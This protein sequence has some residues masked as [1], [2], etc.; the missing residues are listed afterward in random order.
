MK[1]VWVVQSRPQAQWLCDTLGML[2]EAGSSHITLDLQVY[3]T[4]DKVRVEVGPNRRRGQGGI[5]NGGE[6]RSRGGGGRG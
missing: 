3:V 2:Q 6:G 4:R 1:L 5:P